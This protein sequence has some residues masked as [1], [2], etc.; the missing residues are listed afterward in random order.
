MRFVGVLSAVG[1]LVILGQ[2]Y[3][4]AQG[5]SWWPYSFLQRTPET[6]VLPQKSGGPQG[7]GPAALGEED[8]DGVALFCR[9]HG[10]QVMCEIK[11][12]A[13]PPSGSD[14]KGTPVAL[15]P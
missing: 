2:V 15:Q 5:L 10:G 13:T 8:L 11:N 7:E 14:A 4:M 12:S 6:F 1:V 3:V 9:E